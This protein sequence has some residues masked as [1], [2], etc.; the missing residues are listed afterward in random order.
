MNVADKT[1]ILLYKTTVYT[2][3]TAALHV[4]NSKYQRKR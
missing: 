3:V 1:Q 2:L 4:R